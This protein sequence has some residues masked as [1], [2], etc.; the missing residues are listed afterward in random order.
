M[1]AIFN[2]F[3]LF[4]ALN[5]MYASERNSCIPDLGQQIFVNLQDDI[6]LYPNPAGDYF[7]IENAIKIQTVEIINV[8]GRT[9]KTYSHMNSLDNFY[10]GDLSPGLYMVRIIDDSGKLLKTIRLHKK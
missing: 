7:S 6:R 2:F 9:V 4:I 10:I 8:V 5:S 3:L 1:K